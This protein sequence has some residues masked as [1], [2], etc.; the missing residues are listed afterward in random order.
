MLLAIPYAKGWKAYVD[1]QET[2]I[3]RANAC[4]MALR[5]EAGTHEIRMTY[6]TPYLKF[7]TLI[8]V[9]SFAAVIVC[10]M[11]QRRKKV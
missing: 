6:E 11:I 9:V 5:L 4:Y 1:G 2:E 7:G 10:T 3:L 8:S